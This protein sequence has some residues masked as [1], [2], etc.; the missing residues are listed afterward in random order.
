MIFIT[1]QLWKAL[2]PKASKL[3]SVS[4]TLTLVSTDTELAPQRTVPSDVDIT[5]TLG[6]ML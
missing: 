3:K 1:Y 4:A 6:R 5:L 2:K